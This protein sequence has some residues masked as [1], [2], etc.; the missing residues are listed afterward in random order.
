MESHDSPVHEIPTVEGNER[1]RRVRAG[2][3]GQ[4]VRERID[5]A[6]AYHGALYTLAEI[7]Q[8]VGDTLPISVGARRSA[9]LE[10]LDDYRAE[11]IPDDV[12]LKYDD[13]RASGLFSSFW[14]ATP[15]YRAQRQPDPWLLGEVADTSL[16]AVVAHW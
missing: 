3:R 7:Q 6:T 15:V 2:L 5:T 11:R 16:Y 9:V 1:A 10:P 4:V 13:A 8:K 12:L 14:V